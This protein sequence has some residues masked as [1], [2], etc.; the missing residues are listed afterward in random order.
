MISKSI[1][2]FIDNSRVRRHVSGAGKGFCLPEHDWEGT[3]GLEKV[4]H[5]TLEQALRAKHKS[6]TRCVSIS[7]LFSQVFQR[8]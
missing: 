8:W 4:T 2:L 5:A 1:F 3:Y 6:P 7:C